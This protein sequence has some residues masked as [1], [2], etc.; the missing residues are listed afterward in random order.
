MKKNKHFKVNQRYALFK[1][2]LKLVRKSMAIFLSFT[3]IATFFAPSFSLLGSI[4]VKALE[5]TFKTETHTYSDKSSVTISGFLEDGYLSR[6]KNVTVSFD[7]VEANAGRNIYMRVRDTTEYT[8]KNPVG[9]LLSG[10][11]PIATDKSNNEKITY[12]LTPVQLAQ[13]FGTSGYIYLYVAGEEFLLAGSDDNPIQT[14]SYKLPVNY[15]DE[16]GNTLAESQKFSWEELDTVL[17]QTAEISGYD[18]D[19][20]QSGIQFGKYKNLK[21]ADYLGSSLS[22][23]VKKTLKAGGY[24]GIPDESLG[25]PLI[26]VYKKVPGITVH[27]L[28]DFNGSRTQIKADDFITKADFNSWAANQSKI[29]I[30]DYT[31]D[32]NESELDNKMLVAYPGT[33][34]DGL[35]I[36]NIQQKIVA[37]LNKQSIN[38]AEVNLLYYI[39]AKIDV[40]PP[41]TVMVGDKIKPEDIVTKIQLPDND[42]LPSELKGKVVYGTDD[43]GNFVPFDFS[44][45]EDEDG[46]Y[47]TFDDPLTDD[48]TDS[49]IPADAD[50]IQIVATYADTINGIRGWNYTTIRVAAGARLITRYVDEAGNALQTDNV[51]TVFGEDAAKFSEPPA[52]LASG[53]KTLVPIVKKSSLLVELDNVPGDSII[54]KDYSTFS[55]VVNDINGSDG[56]QADDKYGRKVYTLTY[57]Y[58]QP[59]T[60]TGKELTV[61]LNEVVQPTSLIDKLTVN[62]KEVTDYSDV[63]IT[64][65]A[66]K[67]VSTIDTSKRGTFTY[68]LTYDD[69]V[70]GETITTEAKV[71]VLPK[72]TLVTKFVDQFGKELKS[73]ESQ[74]AFGTQKIYFPTPEK[75]GDVLPSV[76]SSSVDYEYDGGNKISGY[77]GTLNKITQKN[78]IT[79][80][81]DR[82]NGAG[83]SASTWTNGSD[84]VFTLTYIYNKEQAV[85]K[86]DGEDKKLAEAWGFP[87]ESIT[88]TTTD[89]DLVRYGDTYK[90]EG[91]DGIKYDSL[92]AALAA[93]PTFVDDG[94]DDA[95]DSKPQVFTVVYT[96]IDVPKTSISQDNIPYSAGVIGL[97]SIGGLAFL[98]KRR[99]FHTKNK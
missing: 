30:E 54:F 11:G 52:E 3:L 1:Q 71:T 12:T 67:I 33:D 35:E 26:L 20:S 81:V 57:V 76:I 28:Q 75:I 50:P 10:F 51:Q 93:N 34:F 36:A 38:T 15:V 6:T 99:N 53:A 46:Q 92:S 9:T 29:A 42:S 14:L 79:D 97:L 13:L 37:Y 58:G 22:E 25:I 72:L 78:D 45:T 86:V 82:V 7:N 27:Y 84:Y 16:D 47:V 87:Q 21:L 41:M 43:N 66:G 90:V 4:D 74:S 48:M 77:S 80:A 8:S 94:L 5:T 39:N 18:L 19:Y 61:N 23:T 40:S 95:T 56:I 88:F 91:P 98:K 2:H 65:S 96:P 83:I 70:S 32:A 59:A 73:D 89:D 63:R 64:D 17:P 55:S 60:L 31:L 44:Q 68:T 49:I 69:E 85:L 62:G 24:S